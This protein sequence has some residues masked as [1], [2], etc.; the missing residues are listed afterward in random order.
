MSTLEITV[1]GAG[2]H[3]K[4]VVATLEASGARVS[5]VLD[6]DP[7]KWGSSLLGVPVAGGID[8]LSA[9]TGPAVLAIGRNDV[10]Q[11][12]AAAYPH[13]DWHTVIHPG[14][15]V[16]SSARVGR[17]TVIFAGAV[18]QPDTVIGDHVILNTSCSADHD[19]VIEAFTHVA[20]GAHLA[21]GVRVGQGCL[22]GVGTAVLPNVH[23]GAWTTVGAGGV[24]I[25]DLPPGV[26][27]VGVPAVPVA[28]RG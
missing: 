22:L 20:P 4:V 14:A 16:H 5:A 6:D 2:G 8:R 13:V 19:C 17:G 3:A 18:V 9:V 15:L 25:R 26:V 7:A 12:I 24:V 10:R 23:I 28:G 21:G 11:R 27:A 1:V